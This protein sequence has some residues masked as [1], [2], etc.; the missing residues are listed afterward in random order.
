MLHCILSQRLC[1]SPSMHEARHDDQP[2]HT[3]WH[4]SCGTLSTLS[5]SHGLAEDGKDVVKRD[6]HVLQLEGQL[7]RSDRNRQQ[8]RVMPSATLTLAPS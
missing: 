1:P 2:P 5:G 4:T 3:E 6:L 7:L 8:L